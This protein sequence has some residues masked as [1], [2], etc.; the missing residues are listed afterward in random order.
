VNLLRNFFFLCLLCGCGYQF[1]DTSEK[2]TISIPYVKG[3]NEGQLTNELIRQFASS[4]A[5]QFVHSG[6]HLRLKVAIIG[7]STDRIGYQ[8][9][10]KEFS[11][12]RER[13]LQANENRR[14]I[15]AEVTLVD[16]RT[17]EVLFGPTHMTASAD[18][19]YVD[20]NSIRDLAFVTPSG[21][22]ESVMQLSLGQLDSV[23]GASDDAIMALYRYL[24]AKIAQAV[25]A[26]DS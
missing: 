11:G 15:T 13:N 21:K 22:I 16:E 3:D 24:A 20:I 10:R 12:K 5:Y 7:D 6:G 17:D 23:E 2:T 25:M 4:G 1:Q 18:Y 19:D 14:N 9:D 8:Y 26:Q